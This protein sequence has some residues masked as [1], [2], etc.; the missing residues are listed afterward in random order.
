MI[1]IMFRDACNFQFIDACKKW[2]GTKTV[3]CFIECWILQLLE[4][5]KI[6]NVH[7]IVYVFICKI[8]EIVN[9][10]SKDWFFTHDFKNKN[11]SNN[12]EKK[13]LNENKY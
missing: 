8:M 3:L 10:S 2:M 5:C 1:I 7:V 11:S 6:K 4:I 9:K 12:W 13:T